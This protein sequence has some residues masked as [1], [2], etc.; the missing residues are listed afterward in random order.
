MIHATQQISL[1]NDGLSIAKENWITEDLHL[2]DINHLRGSHEED[3][4]VVQTV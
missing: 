1:R 3:Y 4:I 2:Q